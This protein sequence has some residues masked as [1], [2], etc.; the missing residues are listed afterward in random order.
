MFENKTQDDARKE[1]LELVKEYHD[2]FHNI[3][4]EFN[5]GDRITYASRVY[6]SEEMV[7][8]VDASLEFWLT[9][10]R[11]FDEFEKEFGKQ[12]G[13]KYVSLVNSGSSANLLAFM[14]LTSPLLG[15]RQVKRCDE[16]IKVSCG[17]PTSV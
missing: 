6:D 10:G 4:K 17:F 5:E 15:E 9:A 14:T 12:F 8:L 16:V 1:I 7:N 2:K 3:K 13:T 11:Y